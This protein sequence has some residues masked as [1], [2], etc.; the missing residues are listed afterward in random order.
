M[1]EI[2]ENHSN[3]KTIKIIFIIDD[4]CQLFQFYYYLNFRFVEYY[5]IFGN[6]SS[7]HETDHT[8]FFFNGKNYIS[9][10]IIQINKFDVTTKIRIVKVAVKVC[11]NDFD[12]GG[13]LVT[14]MRSLNLL[15]M[16]GN[17][18]VFGSQAV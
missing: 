3:I 10:E 5:G 7:S 14:L 6:F 4:I 15:I 12:V 8:V 1:A 18:F 2:L 9:F 11:A 16:S 17:G 13:A